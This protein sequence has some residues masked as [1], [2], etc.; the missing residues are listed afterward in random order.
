MGARYYEEIADRGNTPI[1]AGGTGFYLRALLDGLS[2]GPAR[3]EQLRSR[4]LA[5]EHK[6]SGALHRILT[7]LDPRSAARIHKNDLNKTLR[8]L[9]L[10]LL[11]KAPAVSQEKPEQLS[12]FDVWKIGLNPPRDELYARLNLRL[13]RMF[14]GGLRERKY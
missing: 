1:V 9:E 11:R 3:D 10:R 14:E 4:L 6:R 13:L 2:P 7:R 12:G 5:R 8:A